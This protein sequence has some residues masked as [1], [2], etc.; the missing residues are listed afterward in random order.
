MNLDDLRLFIAV[1]RE[2]SLSGA[3]RQLGRSPA[4]ASAALARLESDRQVRLVVRTTRSLRLTPEGDTFLATCEAMVAVWADGERALRHARH[5][6]MGPLRVA[7]PADLMAQRVAGWAASFATQHPGVRMTLLAGDALHRVAAE[8]VDVAIR[9][10]PLDDSGL[11]VR[12]LGSTRRHLVASPAY[13]ERHGPLSEPEGL[14]DHRCLVWQRHERPFTRWTLGRGR[15]ERTVDVVP[16][17]CGDG[18]LVR[19]W[20]LDGHGIGFKATVDI[21]HDLADGRLV[22]PLPGWAGEAHPIYAVLPSARFQTARV[23]AFVDFV[24]GELRTIGHE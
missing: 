24:Q 15:Q 10:G 17:L 3:A 1:A 18:A 8:G 13:V 23:T 4:A 20:A 14:R 19:Q 5:E 12:R 21:T 6:L 16:W 11:V 9:I 7:A 22:D 2:G